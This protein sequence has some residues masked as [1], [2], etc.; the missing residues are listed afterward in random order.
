[1]EILKSSFI[2]KKSSFT[3]KILSKNTLNSKIL[4][5]DIC[6]IFKDNIIIGWNLKMRSFNRILVFS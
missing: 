3:Y 5:L 6:I 4:L 2:K 1:M